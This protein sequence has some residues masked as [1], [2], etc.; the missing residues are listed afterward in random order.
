MGKNEALHL[1]LYQT[2]GKM[3]SKLPSSGDGEC[4]KGREGEGWGL[5]E[6]HGMRERGGVYWSTSFVDG[7][8]IG[9]RAKRARHS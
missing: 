8:I 2:M 9:E 5:I 4:C 3:Q 1:K 7:C 6:H